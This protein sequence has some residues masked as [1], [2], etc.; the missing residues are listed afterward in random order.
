MI[1]SITVSSNS[2]FKK[3]ASAKFHESKI[4]WKTII[5]YDIDFVDPLFE[6]DLLDIFAYIKNLGVNPM[7][8]CNWDE[9]TLDNLEE[10]EWES[11]FSCDEDTFFA[12]TKYMKFEKIKENLSKKA[13]NNKEKTKNEVCYLLRK[14]D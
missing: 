10:Y 5:S 14:K 2:E 1:N 7:F 4:N 12:L 11:S 6:D 9:L 8:F 13:K 3:L